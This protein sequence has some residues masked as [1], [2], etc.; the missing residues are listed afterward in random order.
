MI[1]K[2]IIWAEDRSRAIARTNR[3][4][5]E[6]QISGVRHNIPFHQV[7]M[8]NPQF[9]E[10][11]YDTS[12]I[13]RYDILN[14]VITHVKDMKSQSSSPKTAAAMAAVQVVMFAATNSTGRPL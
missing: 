7:V 3:A 5:W 10:G 6:F 4:L 12:F 9:K 2:L 14:Q 8:D 13:P 11:T 1:A